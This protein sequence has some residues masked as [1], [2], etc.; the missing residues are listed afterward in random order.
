MT[1]TVDGGKRRPPWHPRMWYRDRVGDLPRLRR[2]R[3]TYS[4]SF[5]R[6]QFT[7]RRVQSQP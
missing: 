5:I 6:T 2:A 7:I 1:A 3:T 4:Q